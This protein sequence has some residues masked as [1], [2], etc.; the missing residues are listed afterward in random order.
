MS[1]LLLSSFL[2]DSVYSFPVE[3]LLPKDETES[4]KFVKKYTEYDGRGVTVAVLDTGVDPSAAGLQKTTD[5]KIK[6]VN[7]IDCSGGL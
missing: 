6:I 2:N 7:L 3:G 5:G 1:E 4:Q